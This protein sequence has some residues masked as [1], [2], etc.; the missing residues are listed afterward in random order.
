MQ[1]DLSGHIALVTG[2]NHGIGAATARA[3][4]GRGAAV[5]ASYL[6]FDPVE[7][8]PG[9]PV[10]YG[11]ARRGGAGEVLEAI[12]ATGGRVE[13]VE[14]DLADPATPARPFGPA[15]TASAGPGPGERGG[16]QRAAAG[17]RPGSACSSPSWPGATWPPGGPGDGS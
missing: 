7:D 12:R 4:A 17:R 11:E 6:R 16:G 10:A 15:R 2:A 13:A 1:P 9:R 5:L 3:L 8:D 14:A